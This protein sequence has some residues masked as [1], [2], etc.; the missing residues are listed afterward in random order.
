[1]EA[2]FI[3]LNPSRMKPMLDLGEERVVEVE[4]GY[5]GGSGGGGPDA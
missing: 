5:D 2:I 1:M 3:K 4:G